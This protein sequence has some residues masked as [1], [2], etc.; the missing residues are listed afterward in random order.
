YPNTNVGFYHKLN[1]GRNIYYNRNYR[2]P[3][4]YLGYGIVNQSIQQLAHYLYLK[5]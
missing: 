2:P 3:P 1:Y 4:Y 5:L